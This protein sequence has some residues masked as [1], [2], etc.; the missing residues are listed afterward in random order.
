MSRRPRSTL[1][2]TQRVKSKEIKEGNDLQEENK[3]EDNEDFNKE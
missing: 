2:H 3:Y 1:T